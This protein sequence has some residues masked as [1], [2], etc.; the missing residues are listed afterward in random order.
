MTISTS[1]LVITK[2]H[3]IPD[4]MHGINSVRYRRVFW[5]RNRRFIDF[6]PASIN[7]SLRRLPRYNDVGLLINAVNQ[8]EQVYIA[9][10]NERALLD[11]KRLFS[12]FLRSTCISV[13][14]AAKGFIRLS[15]CIEGVDDYG[16]P[17]SFWLDVESADSNEK[18][19]R[20]MNYN[21]HGV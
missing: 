21:E 13:S 14:I 16:I 17:C 8:M 15:H 11:F 10:E 12:A 19:A 3:Q 6:N 9:F 7:F 4:Y 1:D 5:C 20:Y 18:M 2:S